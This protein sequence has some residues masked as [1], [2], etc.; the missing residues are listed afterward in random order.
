MEPGI[1]YIDVIL[2]NKK[3]TTQNNRYASFSRLKH[4]QNTF[5]YALHQ[6]ESR[7]RWKTWI[8]AWM[9]KHEESYSCNKCN[10]LCCIPEQFAAPLP[11]TVRYLDQNVSSSTADK[12][13]TLTS[14]LMQCLR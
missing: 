6:F 13:V 12:T 7:I 11:A 2:A 3:T 4:V 8:T 1:T 14:T 10:G 9:C 5:Y